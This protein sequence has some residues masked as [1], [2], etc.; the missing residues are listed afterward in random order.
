MNASFETKKDQ[1][2]PVVKLISKENMCG[3]VS[4]HLTQFTLNSSLH[5][6]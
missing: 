6:V 2:T 1:E 3:E 4:K 5:S